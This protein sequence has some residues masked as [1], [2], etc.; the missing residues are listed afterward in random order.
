MPESTTATASAAAVELELLAGGERPVGQ[1]DDVA[2]G[3]GRHEWFD[4]VVS[5]V[6]LVGSS[7]TR[8]TSWVGLTNRS[9]MTSSSSVV[10]M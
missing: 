6:H 4:H 5:S 9:A 7:R 8:E 2:V 10:S 3:A 1:L